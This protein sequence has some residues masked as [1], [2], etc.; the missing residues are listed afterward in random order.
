MDREQL[1]T[2][3]KVAEEQSFKKA[4]AHLNISEGAVSQRIK[5]LEESL[6]QVLL[7]RDKP[8]TPTAAG[9]A[10]LR[11][12]N[13]LRMLE[14]N[15]RR[16]ISPT[17]SREA[18]VPLAIAVNADSLACWLPPALWT[19]ML[20]REVALEVVA[21]DQEHT[22]ARL[23]HGEVIGCVS[24]RSEPDSGFRAEPL[25]TMEYRCYASPGFANQYFARGLTVDSV[26]K[27]PAVLFNKKDSL[28]DDFLKF[29]FGV[30]LGRY[31]KHYL[32]ASLAL[33][34]G[35]AEGVGYGLIP[36]VQ[37]APLVQS[38]RLTELAPQHPI[39]LPLYWHHWEVEQSVAR[40]I[41]EVV[42]AHASR[43]LSPMEATQAGH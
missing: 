4:A 7:N 32:P 6:A 9:E 26:L 35:I 28:H 22:A 17:P 29:Y 1:E 15:L 3:A 21:D 34:E 14:A 23:A 42:V 31:I 2:F 30:T 11:H 38:G 41:T 18:P 16:E 13:A 20:Q 40:Q 25:G 39:Q 12:V 19:I 27:A 24:M 37:A 43:T 36:S 5:A 8:I 10:L 33:L